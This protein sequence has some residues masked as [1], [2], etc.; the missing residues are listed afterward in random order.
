VKK[1]VKKRKTKNERKKKPWTTKL[2]QIQSNE[3]KKS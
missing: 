1:R 3:K 2:S